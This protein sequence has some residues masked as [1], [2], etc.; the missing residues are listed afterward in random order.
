MKIVLTENF[1]LIGR[2][3]RGESEA[4]VSRDYGVSEDTLRGCLKD[5]EMLLDF[6][7]MVDSSDRM[8]YRRVTSCQSG[9]NMDYE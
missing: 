5:E 9:F 2:V 8:N 7:N 6:V 1:A 3:K 4:N